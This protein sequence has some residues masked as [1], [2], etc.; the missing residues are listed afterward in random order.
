[1]QIFYD[2][3]NAYCR[4]ILFEYENGGQQALGQCR[5]GVDSHKTC[6]KPLSFGFIHE[7]Y[8]RLRTNV[9]LQAAKVEFTHE[10]ERN[11]DRDGWTWF[12]MGG[13]LRFW[14]T[15]ETSHLSVVID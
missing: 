1:V 11:Y 9:R 14:F 8:F 7:S 12:T 10:H 6:V 3:D 2:E 5:L 4:G 15:N 13:N